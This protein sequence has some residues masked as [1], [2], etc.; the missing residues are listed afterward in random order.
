M[1]VHVCIYVY[2]Y[3][4]MCMYKLFPNSAETHPGLNSYIVPLS[5]N[6]VLALLMLPTS[7]QEL[8]RGAGLFRGQAALAHGGS[9]PNGTPFSVSAALTED[10]T[11]TP[12]RTVKV[13]TKPREGHP[14]S[15]IHT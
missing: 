11:L 10:D 15:Y 13:A 12:T 8:L 9:C 4:Y 1:C 14:P 7:F 2:T 6:F 5:F 3:V